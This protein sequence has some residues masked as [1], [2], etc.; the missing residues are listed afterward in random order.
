MIS[1]CRN[2]RRSPSLGSFFVPTFLAMMLLCFDFGV[3]AQQK[4]AKHVTPKKS[5]GIALF[6]NGQRLALNPSPIVYK[7]R[8]L[9]P[10]RR[11][12]EA[13]GLDFQQ[14]GKSITTHVG[15]KT[16]TLQVDSQRAD[17]NGDP[18]DLDAPPVE[19]KYVLYAP[20][21]FF[22]DILGAQASFDRRGN[23]VSI[24]AELIGVSG[25]GIMTK[26]NRVEEVGTAT[27]I[28]LNSDPPT[29]TLTYNASVRTVPVVA[30]AQISLQDVNANA[31]VPG[32]LSDVH[33]GDF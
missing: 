33:P 9:V 27:A 14:S 13:L 17:V 15:Y 8:L 5:G 19:I 4:Q 29:I 26:G 10:V 18:V 2:V 32:E 21:R 23:A 22:T 7:G 31:T 16:V 1:G 12:I 24:V 30:N 25:N 20:L 3:A 11:I 6:L 28:D